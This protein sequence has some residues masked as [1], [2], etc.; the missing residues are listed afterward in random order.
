VQTTLYRAATAI[1]PYFGRGSYWTASLPFA[2]RFCRWLVDT[3]GG[4]HAVYE[5][6]VELADH[7]EVPFQIPLV[8]YKVDAEKWAAAGHR[9]VSFHEDGS[10]EGQNHRQYVYLGTEPISARLVNT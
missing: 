10:F 6:T 2:W 5:A 3:Y 1:E 7:I 9:W 4:E 8:P